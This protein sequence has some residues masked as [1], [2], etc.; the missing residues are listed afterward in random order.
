MQACPVFFVTETLL[1]SSQAQRS[2]IDRLHAQGL[3]LNPTVRRAGFAHLDLLKYFETGLGPDART[4]LQANETLTH[5]RMLVKTSEH[6]QRANA[7]DDGKHMVY[8][9][10]LPLQHP[11]RTAAAIVGGDGVATEEA[12][13]KEFIQIKLETADVS[14][15]EETFWQQL[16]AL[17]DWDHSGTLEKEVCFLV[18]DVLACN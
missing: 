5:S 17:M 13:Q 1:V 10:R 16:V 18:S 4:L 7:S 14:Q 2:A 3:C 6:A 9:L 11:K 8:T 12:D 15:V